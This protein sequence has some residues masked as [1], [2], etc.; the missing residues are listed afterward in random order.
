MKKI[1]ATTLLS[2]AMCLSL[3]PLGAQAANFLIGEHEPLSGKMAR[4]GSGAHR[5]IVAGMYAMNEKYKGV[6]TFELKTIDDESSP[7]KAVSAVEKLAS[8]GVIAFTG[9]YGSNIIG[10]ASEA[11]HKANLPYITFGG[12]APGLSQRGHEGFFRINNSAGYGKAIIGLIEEMGVKK[13]S[14]LFS[15]KEATANMTHDVEGALAKDGI[16]VVSHEF[17]ASTKDFKSVVN[18]IKFQDKP[19]VILMVGYEAD[20][21]GILRAAKVLKPDV[22]AMVGLWG[23]ATGKMA[24]E[25]PDLMENVYGTAMLP[26][27]ATFSSPMAHEFYTAYK[28]SFD[29]EPSY[30]EQFGYVQTR[31]MLEAIVKANDSGNLTSKGISDELRKTNERTVSGHVRFDEHGDNPD[32][33][34]RVGQHQK[35][36]IPLI[37]PAEDATN[38]K[39]FPGV[40]W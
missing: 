26:F 39:V 19:E 23:L 2:A 24:D 10:P 22:K 30:L 5:G 40:P 25:F 37:W 17:D 34:Q 7:A 33:T 15:N 28:A 14:I 13:V 18:K 8:E 27:P 9:G 6:H 20:Y 12:V 3:Q 35:G 4:V 29:D 31:L 32:F 1:T 36:Q 16:E 38:A 11:A 21:I